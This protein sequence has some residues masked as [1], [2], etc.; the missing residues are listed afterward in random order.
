MAVINLYIKNKLHREGRINWCHMGNAGLLTAI[1]GN[2][3]I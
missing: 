2:P 1:N 3:A